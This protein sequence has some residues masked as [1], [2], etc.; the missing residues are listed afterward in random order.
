VFVKELVLE[1]G[2]KMD[3]QARQGVLLLT[4]PL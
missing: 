2:A 4:K 3:K 1:E